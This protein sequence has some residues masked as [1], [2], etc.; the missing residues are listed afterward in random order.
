MKKKVLMGVLVFVVLA[1]IFVFV[2]KDKFSKKEVK[3]NEIKK[4]ILNEN[5]KVDEKVENNENV[6]NKE[7]IL[8]KGTILF[9]SNFYDQKGQTT[10]FSFD[11]K[12]NE[13]KEIIF[14]KK[15]INNDSI[16]YYKNNIYFIN[17]N[18]ELEK[19]DLSNN[20]EEVLNLGEVKKEEGFENFIIS[21]DKLFYLK[22]SC[23]FKGKC[24]VGY[25]DILNSKNEIISENIGDK[26][27]EYGVISLVS[28]DESKNT[29]RMSEGYGDVGFAYTIFYDFNLNYKNIKKLGKGTYAAC[30]NE[31]DNPIGKCNNNMIIENKKYFD[32]ISKYK[33][34]LFCNGV[35]IDEITKKLTNKGMAPSFI[36]C[37]E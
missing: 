27:A 10:I 17:A 28:F 1:G 30:G 11:L 21:D 24:L 33:K 22:G 36:G 23:G 3:N 15:L 6:E 18:D 20:K 26:I 5:G 31:E 13:Q 25:Y 14:L 7:I 9:A 19:L 37:V 16:V 4:E 32:M 34:K 2:F 29:L 8:E 35:N 12:T